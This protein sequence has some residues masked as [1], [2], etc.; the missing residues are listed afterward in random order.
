M[1]SL[2]HP[3]RRFSF[4]GCLGLALLLAGCSQAPFPQSTLD[5]TT[6]F[7][8]EIHKLFTDILWWEIGIFVIVE[9]ALVLALLRFTRR[10]SRATRIRSSTTA[11]P[12]S[13]SGGR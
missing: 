12:A 2:P 7:G 9:G 11:T 6:E 13:K 3:F 8:W 1:P 4:W 5:P 10:T